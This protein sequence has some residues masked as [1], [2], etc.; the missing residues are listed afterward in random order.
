MAYRRPDIR[1][2]SRRVEPAQ[3][4]PG[5]RKIADFEKVSRPNG[6]NDGI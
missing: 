1:V 4:R 3:Q 2:R 5:A 6:G